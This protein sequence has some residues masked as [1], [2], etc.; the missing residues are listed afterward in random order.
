MPLPLASFPPSA[1]SRVRRALLERA[2]VLLAL[3]AFALPSVSAEDLAKRYPATL[4]H[5]N[6]GLAWRCD[7]GDVWQLASFELAIGTDFAVKTKSA[8]VALG[9]SESN[10]L[11]AVVFPDE[12]AKLRAAGTPADG[13][14][15][16]A[17]FLRFA[18]SE[19]GSMFPAK[20]V[21]K[22]LQPRG[23]KALVGIRQQPRAGRPAAGGAQSLAVRDRG[24]PP[25]QLEF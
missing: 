22:L 21:Q 5:S 2:L 1:S 3:G 19:L 8:T 18:P 12:P 10:V 7:E 23:R 4:S 24:F 6:T 9:R 13:E 25:V 15:T 16:S 17:I 14:T 20:T 11:W